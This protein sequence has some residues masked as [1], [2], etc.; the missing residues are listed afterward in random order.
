MK[1]A[2]AAQPGAPFAPDELG[3]L[4]AALDVRLSA[5]EAGLANPDHCESLETL[6]L[7]LARVATEEA[8]VAARR[9]TR[10][11]QLDANKQLTAALA[12]AQAAEAS[13]D[14]ERAVNLALQR[15]LGEVRSELNAER[16]T[17]AALSHDLER[18]RVTLETERATN[19]PLR[20]ELHDAKQRI[21]ASDAARQGAEIGRAH[22]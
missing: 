22:V 16:Q 7:D 9:A 2:L 13:L 4:R 20:A 19:A 18:A 8:E 12:E 3:A 11:A 15:D 21:A 10:Q 14:E 17:T 1:T 5:L 6:V